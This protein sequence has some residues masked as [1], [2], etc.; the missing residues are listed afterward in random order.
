MSEGEDGAKSLIF[1]LMKGV[2]WCE[3]SHIKKIK[4]IVGKIFVQGKQQQKNQLK[5][6][7]IGEISTISKNLFQ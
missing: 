3:E 7:F 2:D 4:K 6:I 1:Q 5:C